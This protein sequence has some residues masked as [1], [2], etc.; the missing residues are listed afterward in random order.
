MLKKLL[1]VVAVLVVLLAA[2]VIFLFSQ[3]DSVV[4]ATIER[5]GTY[6]LQT[7]VTVGSADLKLGEGSLT[8][9]DL[10]VANP[11]GFGQPG[12]RFFGL[13]SSRLELDTDTVQ[14]PVIRLPLISLDGI[15]MLLI[16]D[17]GRA[18]YQ[19]ILDSLKR[20]EGEPGEA[21]PA[22]APDAPPGNQ[23][24]VV[25]DELILT[26]VDVTVRYATGLPGV[27]RMLNLDVPIDEIRLEG[28]GEDPDN[29]VDVNGVISIV[30]KA[31]LA[32][33]IEEAGGVLPPDFTA[34]LEGALQQ[35]VS[36]GDLGVNMATELG[37]EAQGQLEEISRQVEQQLGEV[38]GEIGGALEGARRE[39]GEAA[40]RIGGEI[41]RGIGGLL[42]G[43]RRGG[44]G[45][46]GGDGDGGD[47]DGGSGG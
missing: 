46:S 8:V 25:I 47:G 45:G 35:L 12:E 9:G 23:Q 5:G 41:E 7:P 24:R 34:D 11:E 33:V 32:A 43:G 36:L 3:I 16:K 14:Q 1:I 20:F 13:G 42:P 30:M 38:G 37:A 4:K 6:A 21:P 40:G 15:D 31:L 17:G 27:D 19:T 10:A 18:N 28:V 39:A 22:P 44:S 2:G 29:P 26:N